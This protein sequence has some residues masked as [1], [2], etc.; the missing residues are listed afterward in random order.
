VRRLNEDGELVIMALPT[1]KENPISVALARSASASVLCVLLGEMSSAEA[2]RTV[3][4][5]GPS[6]FI[7]SIVLEAPPPSEA[8]KASR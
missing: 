5:I 7:G 4:R 3:D 6:N 8:V 2:K 1:I